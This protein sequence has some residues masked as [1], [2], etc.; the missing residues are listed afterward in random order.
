MT[1][2]EIQLIINFFELKENRYTF[3][4]K[5]RFNIYF[6]TAVSRP[7]N[8]IIYIVVLNYTPSLSPTKQITAKGVASPTEIPTSRDIQ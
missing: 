3:V 4:P 7:Q 6:I 2:T 8:S 1:H 5:A